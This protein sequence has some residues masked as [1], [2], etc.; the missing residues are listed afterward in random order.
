VLEN[1]FPQKTELLEKQQKEIFVDRK[2]LGSYIDEMRSLQR[3]L[4][5]LAP[6]VSL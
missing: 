5:E 6:T 3:S 4:L 2:R 1:K